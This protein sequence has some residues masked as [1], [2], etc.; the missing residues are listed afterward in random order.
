VQSDVY[1]LWP[2]FITGSECVLD[3]HRNL[4]RERCSNISK[5][6]GFFN[7][8]SCLELLEKI[9]A[10]HPGRAEESNHSAPVD[11]IAGSYG[12]VTSPLN[13]TVSGY[14]GSWSQGNAVSASTQ[15]CGGQGFRWHHI[16]QAK[17]ADGEYM[18]V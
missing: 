10:Q 6:S 15:R 4:I 7:N 13:G 17:R 12:A 11:R 14:P 18:V 8:L 3:S 16:M 9:W 2:L 5:D 1:L